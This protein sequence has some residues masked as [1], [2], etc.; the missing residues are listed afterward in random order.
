MK[1]SASL[2]ARDK[3][4]STFCTFRSN[5]RSEGLNRGMFGHLPPHPPFHRVV[6]VLMKEAK[7]S[8]RLLL[9]DAAGAE[10]EGPR[11]RELERQVILTLMLTWYRVIPK[12]VF[13]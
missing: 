5:N 1:F 13:Y 10:N 9:R 12:K 4:N 7:R 3:T 8:R 6:E 11:M 2:F